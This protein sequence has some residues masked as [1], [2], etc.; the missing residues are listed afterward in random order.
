LSELYPEVEW[1]PWKFNHLPKDYWK[2]VSNQKQ[3]FEYCK[4]QLKIREPED[5]YNINLSDV[6]KLGGRRLLSEIYS[7]NLCAALERVYPEHNWL[8]WKFPSVPAGFWSQ[9]SNLKKYVEWLGEQLHITELSDW[10]RVSYDD[11]RTLKG[12]YVVYKFG[13]LVNLLTKVYP[14]HSWTSF[15]LLGSSK[16]ELLMFQY[17][18]QLF[19]GHLS[20]FL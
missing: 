4:E 1:H 20:D 8:A 10:K 13:G 17:S 9:H 12:H 15:H 16:S 3:F 5:W 7:N 14:H 11:L 18:K 19:P 6:R 2:D